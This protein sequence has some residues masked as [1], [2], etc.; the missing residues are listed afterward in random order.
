MN[1]LLTLFD[2][3]AVW[4]LPKL[5]LEKKHL[6]TFNYIMLLELLPLSHIVSVE[7]AIFI[8]PRQNLSRHPSRLHRY[9]FESPLRKTSSEDNYTDAKTERN[10]FF[11]ECGPG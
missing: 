6:K 1:M 11:I 2:L 9:P 10:L 5:K 4:N 3:S 8:I 7:K